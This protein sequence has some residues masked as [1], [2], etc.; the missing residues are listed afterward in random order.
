M[1]PGEILGRGEIPGGSS[2]DMKQKAGH[3]G[4]C[5]MVSREILGRGRYFPYETKAGTTRHR[6]KKPL[7]RERPTPR[8][9]GLGAQGLVKLARQ[10][11][12]APR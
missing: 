2:P 5:R 8:N 7:F 3:F 11:D 4:A 6:T 12:D 10:G 9:A 1:V